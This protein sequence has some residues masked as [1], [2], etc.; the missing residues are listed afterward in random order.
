MSPKSWLMDKAFS[1]LWAIGYPPVEFST[2]KGCSTGLWNR[3]F[4][5]GI[6]YLCMKKNNCGHSTL[7]QITAPSFSVR[8]N[9]KYLSLLEY[10]AAQTCISGA[11]FLPERQRMGSEMYQLHRIESSWWRCLCYVPGWLLHLCPWA[12][13]LMNHMPPFPTALWGHHSRCWHGSP[14]PGTWETQSYSLYD[15]GGEV[16]S[17]AVCEA[18]KRWNQ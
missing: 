12:L 7:G 14:D 1:W 10:C 9:M 15:S 16:W 3:M 5:I 11:R 6:K 2:G 8:W 13:S 17:V 18:R 4:L